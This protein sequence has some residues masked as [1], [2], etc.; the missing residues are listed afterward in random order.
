MAQARA[1]LSRL[2]VLRGLRVSTWEGIWATVWTVLTTGAFQTGFALLLGATPFALG[3]LAGLPAVVGLLQLPAS[4]LGERA[5]ERRR[6]VGGVSLAGRLLWAVILLIPFALPAPVRLPVFLVLLTLSSALLTIGV[7]AWTSW[8][9]DLVPAASRGQYF[10]RR[11]MLAGVVAMLVP[12][13]AGAFLDQAVKYHRFDPVWAFAGLFALACVAAGA[14]FTMLL[15][16]P[17]PPLAPREAAPNPLHSLAAP[18]QDSNFCRFLVF[19]AVVVC[20]QTLAGQFFVAWQVDKAALALPYLTVQ[21]LG[22]VAAGAG[23]ASTPVW[24]YLADKY[25]ARPVLSLSAAGVVIAPLI[26]IFTIPR[27]DALAVNIALIVLLNIFS[28]AAWGG[29]GLAQFNLLLGIA[30]P[31]TRATYVAVFSA[32]TGLVGGVSPVVGGLLMGLLAHTALPLGPLVLNNYKILFL[33]TAFIRVGS[34]F[35]LSAVREGDGGATSTRYVLGQITS[36][37]PVTSLRTLRRLSRPA[38][39]DERRQAVDDLAQLRS[40]LAVEE[41]VTALDDVSPDVREHAV[42]ALGAIGDS[43]AVPALVEKLS[44]PA[45]GVGDLAADALGVIGDAGAAPA[46]AEASG[47]PDAGVRVAALRAL[48]LLPGAAGEPSVAPALLAALD[49]AHPTACE[50]AC[51]ALSALGGDLT[52]AIAPHLLPRLLYLLSQEVDRGVRLGAAR[53]LHAVAPLLATWPDGYETLQSRLHEEADPAVV[54]Q[55][56][57][58]LGRV[59]REANHDPETLL[60]SLLPVLGR[61]GMRGIAYKQVLEV[62]ADLGLEPGAFYRYLGLTEMRRDET[63]SRLAGEIARRHRLPPTADPAAW[64]AD[65]LAAYTGGDYAGCLRLLAQ[66]LPPGADTPAALALHALYRT[67]P[68]RT[69][70]PDEALLG[71][72]LLRDAV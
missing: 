25:G 36:A 50:A 13:P 72:V 22:A 31:Q 19:A 69:P 39:E 14:A 61:A 68:Q 66:T 41:L 4:V 10:G 7:P 57:V 26:W 5:G 6:F 71:A 51:A 9:S 1:E 40:P 17:E 15:R 55:I 20:G 34:L 28:G 32:V 45:A 62:I 67:S 21:L 63:F 52:P 42:R 64:T 2:D 53:A 49:P 70:R 37:R 58:A 24:G 35:L 48:A 27:P 47:G 3:L 11:N 33:L 60:A 46:L 43:R 23:L 56:T 18:L 12:L 29:V 8:M 44:D 65:L 30:A 38:G 54:A 16:Q 59:G